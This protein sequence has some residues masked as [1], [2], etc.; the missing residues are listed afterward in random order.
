MAHVSFAQRLKAHFSAYK[1]RPS[2]SDEPHRS[3]KACDERVQKAGGVRA[4]D[5]LMIE[6]QREI[7]ERAYHKLT[8]SHDSLWP[9]AVDAEDAELGGI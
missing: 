6:A 4:I 5:P 7:R 9:S 8:S 3:L 2:F 1:T